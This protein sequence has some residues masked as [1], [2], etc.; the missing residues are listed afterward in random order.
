MIPII[1]IV[2]SH[3]SHVL[4]SSGPWR[5]ISE[6]IWDRN[7]FD[8][9]VII[10]TDSNLHNVDRFYNKIKVAW[11]L[12]SPVITKDPYEWIR[13]NHSKFDYVFTHSKKLLDISDKFKF[14]P[15][16]GCWILDED[17][18]IHNKTKNISIIKSHKV[19]TEGQRL[20]HQCSNFIDSSD[21]F[22]PNA[23]GSYLYKAVSLKDYRF[24]VVV[25]NC[26]EDFYFSE[27]IIDCFA[28]GTIPIYWGCPSIN[29]FFDENGILSFSNLD[30]FKERINLTTESEYEKRFES[31]KFNFNKC[32]E[33]FLSEDF[34]YKN[35]KNIVV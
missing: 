2:D 20:R 26:R 5:R 21:I 13:H 27:K 33:Y 7:N 25:E 24:Q 4:C 1:S 17:I 9:N 29:N 22:T 6:F 23:D 35:Y 31:V 18:E 15:T 3:F 12:E 11:L 34:I 14:C 32:R 16:G 30:E 28:T 8:K 19:D 10:I